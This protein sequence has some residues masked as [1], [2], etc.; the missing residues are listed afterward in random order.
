[1]GKTMKASASVPRVK[2]TKLTKSGQHTVKGFGCLSTTPKGPCRKPRALATVPYCKACMCSGDPS[3]KVTQHP[4]FG[5]ILLAARDIPKGYYIGWWGNLMAT[6]KL[7][8]KNWEWALQ[9]YA[10]MINAVGQKGSQLKFTAC[11][12]PNEQPVVD[13]APCH[14][15]LLKRQQ[16]MGCLI[17]RTKQDIPKGYQLT[18][19]YNEDEKTTE[20]F[21]QEQGIT[22]ADVGTKRY[23]TIRKPKAGLAPWECKAKK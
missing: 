5:K 3:L 13:F 14:D 7:P 9:T 16:K 2:G 6:K 8:L 10:G 1:M 11:V 17:F 4:K 20:E 23:P 18:M 21:F 19:M 22:R 15:V 12:G